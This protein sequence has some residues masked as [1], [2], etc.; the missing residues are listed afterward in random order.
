M[1]KTI[2]MVLIDNG[3]ALNVCPLR[4]ASCL[5]IEM[6]DLTPSDQIVKAYDSTRREVLGTA[7]M[8]VD[9]GPVTVTASFQVIDV[10]TSF[11]LLLGRPWIHQH[12]AVPSSL[13]QKVKFPYE[14]KIIKI[15]GDDYATY[16]KVKDQP[17]YAVNP[18]QALVLNM[19]RFNVSKER[20]LRLRSF[21]M[22][23]EPFRSTAR[24]KR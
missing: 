6:K 15:K 16:K 2:P 11:N 22:I 21:L 18:E 24:Q 8:E 1:N 12:K 5:G 4:V 10:P 19:I 9:I 13:H 23:L 17:L 7:T 3:S 20:L 14:G